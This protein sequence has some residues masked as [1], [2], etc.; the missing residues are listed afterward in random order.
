M[1]AKTHMSI[2]W[3]VSGAKQSGF[4]VKEKQ[5]VLDSLSGQEDLS[6]VHFILR[7]S[8]LMAPFPCGLAPT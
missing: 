8:A 4:F 3:A 6:I 5:F 7:G 2:D 1:H